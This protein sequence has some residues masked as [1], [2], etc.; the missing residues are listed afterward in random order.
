[1]E[2]YT[3]DRNF[4]K[5]HIIDG[6]ESI[7]WTE[8]YYGDGDVELVVPPTFDMILKLLPGTLISVNNSEE[9]MLLE[10]F[11]IE[12]NKLKVKGISLLPWMDNRFVRTSAAHENKYWYIAGQPAGQVLW[13][14]VYNMCCLGSPYLNGTIPIGVTSPEQL[15]I[16]GLGLNSYDTSGSNVAIGVPYGPV[17]TALREIATTYEIGMKITLDSVSDSSYSLGFRSYKGLD[18]T[19]GQSVNPEVKFSPQMESLADIKELQSIAALKTLVYVFAPGNPDLLATT[20][21][22]SSLTGQPNTGFELRALQV[23]ADDITTDMIGGSSANL[24]N[25]LNSR[26]RDAIANN[27]VID[28]VDGEIVPDSQFQYGVHYNLGDLIEVEG[29]SRTIKTKRIIEYIRAQDSGGERAYPTV[30]A[31]N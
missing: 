31:I 16:P 15:V 7:I 17:Y 2:P 19:S 14:I 20:P 26:A 18:R 1:M 27:S 13:T 5:Q 8:R 28:S 23:F 22:V 11:N 3:L 6:F 4:K 29:N 10:T 9:V 25:I 24:L 21:G 30:A 12:N